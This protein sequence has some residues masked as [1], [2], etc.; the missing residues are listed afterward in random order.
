MGRASL[1]CHQDAPREHGAPPAALALSL[2]DGL[3][4]T[5]HR[6][7]RK[8]STLLPPPPP[9]SRGGP[10]T[11][12]GATFLAPSS[13]GC[14]RR[15]QVS[16]AVS[17]ASSFPGF[18]H[19]ASGFNSLHS[20]GTEGVPG[21][22]ETPAPTMPAS[23]LRTHLI[24]HPLGLDLVAAGNVLNRHPQTAVDSNPFLPSV[25]ALRVPLYPNGHGWRFSDYF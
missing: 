18:E 10:T 25:P 15:T 6:R 1:A 2:P 21:E 12:S 13:T 17:S 16:A 23:G 5:P 22:R 20:E 7:D 9:R 3:P 8:G 19:G 24:H 4:P 11:P 14:L